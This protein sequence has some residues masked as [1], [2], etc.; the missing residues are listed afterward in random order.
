MGCLNLK[1]K[2]SNKKS[3]TEGQFTNQRT[4]RKRKK[5]QYPA[6]SCNKIKS[7]EKANALARQGNTGEDH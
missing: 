5:D 1:E 6:P 3:N 2:N 7:K 4:S